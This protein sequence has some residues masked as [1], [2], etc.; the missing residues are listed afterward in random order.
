MSSAPEHHEVIIV[1]GGTGGLFTARKLL[2]SGTIQDVV[3]LESRGSVGGRVIT[4]R[5][6]DGNPL[7][8]NF[9]WRISEENTM[10]LEL[11]K[12]LGLNLIPQTTPPARDRHEEGHG[13][14]RH[15]P[16]SCD[17][18]EEVQREVP[19]NRAP[20]SD[21]AKAGL[22]VSAAEADFQVRKNQSTFARIKNSSF[23]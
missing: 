22:A 13:K 4:T 14:C 15:G 19:K 12:E 11:S 17:R 21:F 3:V 2:A 1:G 20:L 7:F 9:A 23:S 8:N 5:D 16:Y 6:G 10:M 18:K